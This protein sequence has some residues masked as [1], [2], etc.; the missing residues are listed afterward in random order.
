MKKLLL[1]LGLAAFMLS[2]KSQI[3][4]TGIMY[5]PRGADSAVPGPLS[6]ATTLPDGVTTYQHKGG[7]EYAQFMATEAIDFSVNNY[8]VVFCRN[9]GTTSTTIENGWAAGGDRTYKF[10]LTGGTVAKGQFFY[11]GGPEQ[12]LAGYVT[13]SGITYQ[14]ANISS[15][16]WIKTI[17]HSNT[18]G[19]GFGSA[20]T[21]LLPNSGNPGGV[22]VFSGTTVTSATVPLDVA[23]FSG[24]NPIVSVTSVY[25]SA[26]QWGYR[27]PNN[28]YYNT[29]DT[30]F[31][32]GTNTKTFLFING[33]GS[34]SDNGS[35]IKL[36]GDYNSTTSTWNVA[37][38]STNLALFPANTQASASAFTLADIET[39]GT[40]LPVTLTTFTAKANKAG[41][42]NLVWST[43]SEKDNAYY[44]VTRS[45]DGI[46]FSTIA[47][48][49]GSGTSN[50]LQNYNYTDTKPVAGTN[51]YRLKQ[52]D[53]DGKSALSKIVSATVGLGNGN[54]TV[55]VAA[56]RNTVKVNYT[57]VA[58]GNASFTIFNASGVKI[59][60]VN[61][62]VEVGQNRIEIPVALGNSIHILKATQ[63]GLT[64][65]TKF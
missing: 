46:D 1:T 31:G 40:T 9:P 12:V 58:A 27:V 41:T 53:N 10:D 15:A 49:T 56:N 34:A 8:S 29:A 37:R 23:F 55:S 64:S 59:A 22:A 61:K 47:K 3:I 42:V 21:A 50:T 65:S 30:F 63:A 6:P 17:V 45:S 24:A 43:A 57:A 20:T 14:S 5:D 54:L 18:S 16:K 25:N 32:K 7:Y 35:Y 33:T 39:G 38:S 26:N 19:D 13:V 2:A 4:V 44:D 52:V 36:G 11:V 51:Y 28:D 60:T 62:A 48:V